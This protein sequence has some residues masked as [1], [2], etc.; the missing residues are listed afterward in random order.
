MIKCAK[1]LVKNT[2]LFSIFILRETKQICS[3]FINKTFRHYIRA[4]EGSPSLDLCFSQFTALGN[5]FAPTP[6][7]KNCEI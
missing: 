5:F 6:S 3:V 4:A 7:L 1:L 2:K